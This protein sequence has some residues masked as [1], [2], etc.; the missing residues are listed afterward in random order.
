MI[1]LKKVEVRGTSEAGEFAG[2]LEFAGGLQVI[3]A[4]NA[5][6]KSLAVKS[7][8]WCL[9]LDSMFGNLENDPIR[10]PQAV[11]EELELNGHKSRVLSSECSIT[12]EDDNGR[13]LEITRPVAGGDTKFVQV[14]EKQKGQP[15]RV[16]TLVSRRKTMEDEHGGFQRFFFEW[17]NWP[18]VEVPTFRGQGVGRVQRVDAHRQPRALD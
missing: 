10:L 14:R 17:M 2:T 4:K 18:R 7:V 15:D 11:R 9:G 13:T 5:Y 12:L 3:S 16:S 8:T 1:Q 6:G